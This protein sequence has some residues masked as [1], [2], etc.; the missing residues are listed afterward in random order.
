VHAEHS[1]LAE[2]RHD[3]PGQRALLEPVLDV[4]QHPVASEGAHGVTDEPFLVGQLVVDLQQVRVQ[5]AC[6]HGRSSRLA[7]A[8]GINR[9]LPD[10][11]PPPQW[12]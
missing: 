5:R 12:A 3:V 9:D 7:Q 6:G 11:S 2:L 10:V 8:Q 1:Q 4:R